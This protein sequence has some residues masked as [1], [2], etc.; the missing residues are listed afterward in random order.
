MRPSRS[1]PP[2]KRARCSP[3][4]S[5]GLVLHAQPLVAEVQAIKVTVM[6]AETR[7]RTER[8]VG[9][10]AIVGLYGADGRRHDGQPV[11]KNVFGPC[12]AFLYY[13]SGTTRGDGYDDSW[14]FGNNVGGD[15]AWCFA[16][17]SGYPPPEQGWHAPVSVGPLSNLRVELLPATRQPVAPPRPAA[18]PPSPPASIRQALL[19]E[20]EG[21]HRGFRQWHRVSDI[22]AG[23]LGDLVCETVTFIGGSRETRMTRIRF[24]DM[25][26]L[27]GLGSVV[28]CADSFDPDHPTWTDP[29][30]GFLWEWHRPAANRSTRPFALADA[31][32]GDDE[33]DEVPVDGDDAEEYANDDQVKKN[34]WGPRFL[35]A[36]FACARADGPSRW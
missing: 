20:W 17:R 13:W 18:P 16:R 25:L 22:G 33:P 19:G 6:G 5:A 35:R 11:Y 8:G 12:A 31:D 24:E 28:L 27:W 10:A 34:L 14:W 26:A 9:L 32:D 30:R 2:A 7:S 23:H 29:A 4:A 21:T 1:P 3:P 36:L 15:C